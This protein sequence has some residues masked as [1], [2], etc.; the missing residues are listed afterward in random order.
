MRE[1]TKLGLLLVFLTLINYILILLF[2]NSYYLLYFCILFFLS[3]YIGR[4]RFQIAKSVFFISLLLFIVSD[5]LI[6]YFDTSVF[7]LYLFFDLERIYTFAGGGIVYILSVL[8][9]IVLFFKKM[10]YNREK[11][12]WGGEC[13]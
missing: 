7:N 1:K 8:H 4:V 2:L 6:E 13:I 5:F 12:C 9:I 3:L 10:I 11:Y